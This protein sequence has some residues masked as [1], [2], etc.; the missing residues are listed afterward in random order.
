MVGGAL[1]VGA[2][3]L[4]TPS[5]R[6]ATLA[7]S[8]RAAMIGLVAVVVAMCTFALWASQTTARAGREATAANR[9]AADYLDAAQAVSA[10]ESLER[11]YRLQPGDDV[12]AAHVVAAR[13]V[14]T[15]LGR[16]RDE[17]SPD[18]R[19]AVATILTVHA[20][21]LVLTDKVFIAVDR[22]DTALV[23]RI[24][25]GE[26][27][28]IFDDVQR[29]V[30]R[31]AD[32]RRAYADAQLA[33][34]RQVS[35]SLAWGVPLVFLVGLTLS[36][37]FTSILRRYRR[38]LDAQRQRAL[39]DSRHDQLTGLPNRQLLAERLD[40]AVAGGERVGLVLLD[41]D[42]FKEI[43][44]TLGHRCGDEMLSQIGP[45]LTGTVRASDT[46]AR[47]GGDEF[48]VLLPD[49]SG[50]DDALHVAEKLRL[51]TERPLRIAGADLSIEASA[52]VVVSGEH[53]DDAPTLLQRAEVAMYVAKERKRGVAVYEASEDAHDPDRLALV[54]DLRRAIDQR[55]LILHYQ[56][57][58][59]LPGGE[60]CGVEALVRWEHP[61]RGLLPPDQFIPLAEHTSLIGP[62]TRY[63]L[64]TALRQARQW[65]DTGHRLP[66]AVNLAARNLADPH[67][68]D[69]VL[70]LLEIH[71]VAP[72]LLC[73]ELTESA[74]TTEP[75]HA[76]RLTTR[77]RAAGVHLAID[78]FGTGYTSL[79]QLKNLPITELKI[80]RTFV[81]TMSSDRSNRLIVRSIVDLGRN[82]GFTTVAEGVEDAETLAALAGYGCAVA[83]G[84]HVSRPLPADAFD[85]WY[86]SRPV[87]V[88]P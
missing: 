44:D 35:T 83:Q 12:R 39:H 3:D 80:D 54:A 45:R 15:A 55:E 31:A 22:G 48:A 58:V 88:L 32:Q 65:A 5:G 77:L 86:A 74:I 62:L 67:L 2:R 61:Q 71:D 43:N 56:P 42:R 52:G 81:G 73:L 26:A 85:R 47:L 68:Y 87:T 41:L 28:P 76:L 53:G 11:K 27:D 34:M 63:V 60:V 64:D 82:L 18:D 8:S 66:V 14:I 72:Q 20:K 84:Y 78:D 25:D 40:A 37:M 13:R 10:E 7:R 46:V 1:S 50:L 6:M 23:E 19:D 17:G 79:A 38:D 70:R 36:L 16:V 33:S 57:K 30:D 69:D 9:L 21:Y 49:I 4:P 24:D 51:A 29:T 75:E 59:A